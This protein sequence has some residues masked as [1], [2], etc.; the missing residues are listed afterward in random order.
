VGSAFAITE[1]TAVATR[2][3]NTNPAEVIA[4]FIGAAVAYLV[5]TL[6]SG[7]ALGVLER[8]VVVLR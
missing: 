4:I 7:L 6:S 1:I 3:A 8:R 5:I 2:L